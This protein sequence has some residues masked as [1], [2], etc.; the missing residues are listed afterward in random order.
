MEHTGHA[1][2]HH[3]DGLH[4]GNGSENG[5]ERTVGEAK[6]CNLVIYERGETNAGAP[7]FQVGSRESSRTTYP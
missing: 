2:T 4:Q 7:G 3:G 5:E 6:L 1:S